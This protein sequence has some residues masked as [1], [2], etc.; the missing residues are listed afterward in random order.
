MKGKYIIKK[1]KFLNKTKEK[2]MKNYGLDSADYNKILNFFSTDDKNN[3]Q[4]IQVYEGSNGE[5]VIT[6]LD[7]SDVSSTD[8]QSASRAVANEGTTKHIAKTTN[9]GNYVSTSIQPG[10][11]PYVQGCATNPTLANILAVISI[12]GVAAGTASTICNIIFG[13]IDR[14]RVKPNNPPVITRHSTTEDKTSATNAVENQSPELGTG[15]D[16]NT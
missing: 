8:S 6:E 9:A 7:E 10:S 12:I 13:I 11:A 5:L 2:A 16:G 3:V 14:R 1:Q 15:A 4:V